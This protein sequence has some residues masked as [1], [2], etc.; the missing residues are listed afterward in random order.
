MTSE[1]QK[2]PWVTPRIELV[3]TE[4]DTE[5]GA[6]TGITEGGHVVTSMAHLS[7]SSS[8]ATCISTAGCGT[9]TA[10]SS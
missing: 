7:A 1:R 3:L 8:G 4:A 5:G 10:S 9:G 2:R 6:I